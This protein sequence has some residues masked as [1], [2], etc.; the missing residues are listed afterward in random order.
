MLALSLPFFALLAQLVWH[1]LAQ[2]RDMLA[3]RHNA[4]E[5]NAGVV[6]V[7][8]LL[9]MLTSALLMVGALLRYVRRRRMTEDE[10]RMMLQDTLW[11]DT[12]GE[13][14]WFTRWL[15]WFTLD[16]NERKERS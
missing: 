16:Q 12:R 13:Q 10:A 2:T 4:E 3:R 15:A 1:Y 5:W 11:N 6:R 9:T 14:R 7:I 8:V